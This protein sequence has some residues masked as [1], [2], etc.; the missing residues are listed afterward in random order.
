MRN[1]PSYSFVCSDG[2]DALLSKV[3]K[4][5]VRVRFPGLASCDKSN[6]TDIPI[7]FT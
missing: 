4:S 2:D 5:A 1:L 3:N 6:D 7:E